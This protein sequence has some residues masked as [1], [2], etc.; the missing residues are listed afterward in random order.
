[1]LHVNKY[2]CGAINAKLK[3]LHKLHLIKRLICLKF[4]L[5]SV[6]FYFSIVPL[7]D[8]NLIQSLIYFVINLL[9]P[10]DAHHSHC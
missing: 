1:M 10:Y 9:A 3:H 2:T 6:K 7:L 8:S 4:S 5:T